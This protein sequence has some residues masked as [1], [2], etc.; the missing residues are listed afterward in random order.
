MIVADHIRSRCGQAF[1]L[2]ILHGSISNTRIK[3]DRNNCQ[4][5]KD[6]DIGYIRQPKLIWRARLR[7]TNYLPIIISFS[8]SRDVS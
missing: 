1:L 8:L 3:S 7:A 6:K 4:R 2:N 5:L